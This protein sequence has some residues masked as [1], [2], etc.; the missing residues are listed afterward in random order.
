MTAAPMWPRSFV[1]TA[2]P[3]SQ[4]PFSGPRRQ[5]AGTMTSVKKTSSNSEPPVI[6]RSGRISTPGRRMSK[7]K[8]EMPRCFGSD[9][10]GAGHQDAPVAVAPARAPH[11]LTVDDVAVAVALGRRADSDA[12]SLPAPGSLKSWHQTWSAASVWR[13][14]SAC[15]CSVPKRMMAWPASTM[16]TM[17]MN[18]GTPA[19]AH[20]SIQTALC[21]GRE[22]LAAPLRRASG[23]RPI[24]PRRGAAATPRPGRRVRAAGW[25]RS[26]VARRRRW[27]PA[28]CGLGREAPRRPPAE[29]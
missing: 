18:G 3:T 15:C 20:S 10:V 28:R 24:R 5:S 16:P 17:L 12:R 6:W 14:W 22:A 11:L 13:R 23:C 4:P 27:P 21:C 26:R 25:R 9:A 29:V 2:I 19:R 1:S 7:R 8:N